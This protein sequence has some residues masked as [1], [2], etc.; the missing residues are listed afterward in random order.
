MRDTLCKHLCCADCRGPLVLE[1]GERDGDEIISGTLSCGKCEQR[2]PIVRG[3]P[4]F[5][6]DE[7]SGDVR[8]TA[9]NF[10]TSWKIWNSIDDDRYHAQLLRWMPSLSPGAPL[11]R[12]ATT[13]LSATWPSSTKIFWPDR[14]KPPLLGT[15]SLAMP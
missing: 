13:S 3:V 15:A 1:P 14:R 12:A 6:G 7:L 8:H 9:K 4:R 10:G 11:V 2:W 5:V